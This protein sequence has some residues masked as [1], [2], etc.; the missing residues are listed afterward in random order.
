MS[1]P[2]LLV[3]HSLHLTIRGRDSRHIGTHHWTVLSVLGV[4]CRLTTA[5]CFLLWPSGKNA[6]SSLQQVYK[7]KRAEL[8]KIRIASIKEVLERER[9]L[10]KLEESHIVSALSGRG[11]E[12]GMLAAL[13]SLPQDKFI[14]GLAAPIPSE[15]QEPAPT[16]RTSNEQEDQ[17]L[18]EVSTQEGRTQLKWVGVGGYGS[19][20]CVCGRTQLKWVCGRIRLK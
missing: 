4:M 7:T 18:L 11:S 12:V 8:R 1:D 2:S 14:A 10:A 3:T 9:K 20:G 5:P 15:T 17:I 16:D 13:W 19:S 6:S